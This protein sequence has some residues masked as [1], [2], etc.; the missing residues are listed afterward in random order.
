MSE[1]D[2]QKIVPVVL[3]AGYSSR[4][5]FPKALLPLEGDT[6]L[7]RIL[8]TLGE[9]GFA[10]PIVM[11]GRDAPK[12]QPLLAGTGARGRINPDPGRGQISSIKLA[13][14]ELNSSCTGCMIWPVDHPAVSA[15]TV[16]VLTEL[17]LLSEAPIV[18]PGY[19]GRRGHPAIFRRDLFEEILALPP[20]TGLK[21][22][23][24]RHER[25]IALVE[26]EEPGVTEDIDT[27][28]DYRR[29]LAKAPKASD[30]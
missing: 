7:T 4:M 25:E 26:T 5:G 14:R 8:K 15:S 16:R 18:L 1:A 24:F 20:D 22:V 27:I 30:E 6:F 19:R 3:A 29:L 12:I 21:E 23:V 13:V 28:E 17:F 2:L 10:V 11:L 9:L